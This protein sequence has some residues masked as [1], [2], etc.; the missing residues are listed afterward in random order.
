LL[1]RSVSLPLIERISGNQATPILQGI[2]EGWLGGGCLR[3][4]VDHLRRTGRILRPTR[5][6]TPTHRR[7][8]PDWFLWVLPDNRNLLGRRD[9]VARTP[10]VI[11]RGSLEVLLDDLLPPRQ[12]VAS[13]H[14]KIMACPR[15]RSVRYFTTVPL[16]D[17]KLSRV[18]TQ[19]GHKPSVS[20]SIRPDCYL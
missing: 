13:A 19:H 4:G 1:R 11:P 10:I 17:A 2:T 9:I 14:L 3:S 18:R 6:Q 20:Q 16:L 5:N 15:K 12:S 7:N 8:L